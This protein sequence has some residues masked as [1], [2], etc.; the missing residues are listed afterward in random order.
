MSKFFTFFTG[1]KD[2]LKAQAQRIWSGLK[3]KV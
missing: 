3:N 2:Y 1:I